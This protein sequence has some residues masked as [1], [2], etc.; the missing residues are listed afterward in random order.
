MRL[1]TI[2]LIL[3][4]ATPA[5][6]AARAQSVADIARQGKQDKKATRVITN[7]D[8]PSQPDNA[9][10][11]PASAQPDSA[12]PAADAAK[13]DAKAASASADKAKP[14]PDTADVVEAKRFVKAKQIQIDS[15]GEQVK[16]LEEKRNNAADAD[17]AADYS[18]QIENLK[19]NLTVWGKQ[20]SEAQAIIDE[21]NR[22]KDEAGRSDTEKKPDDSAPKPE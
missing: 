15:V 4:L 21:A 12:Q 3:A 8:I 17:Q 9:A 20:Q 1:R 22:K 18:Q 14:A 7:D 11:Q 19:H 5:M 2:L 16:L 6:M 10:S 13:T